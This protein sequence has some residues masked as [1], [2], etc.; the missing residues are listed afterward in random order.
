MGRKHDTG[1]SSSSEGL[2]KLNEQAENG[3]LEPI[4]RG[5]PL[6]PLPSEEPIIIIHPEPTTVPLTKSYVL[7][8]C[9]RM[10]RNQKVFKKFCK[11]IFKNIKHLLDKEGISEDQMAPLNVIKGLVKQSMHDI[12]ENTRSLELYK[13]TLGQI[14]DENNLPI[15]EVLFLQLTFKGLQL[16]EVCQKQNCAYLVKIKAII[17]QAKKPSDPSASDE[18]QG[19]LDPLEPDEHSEVSV[20]GQDGEQAVE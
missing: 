17:D 2:K 7:R 9:D 4:V 3:E 13:I 15:I 18:N 1:D 20:I 6:A 12:E 8:H 19:V 11:Q 16:V 14:S 10:L 5:E